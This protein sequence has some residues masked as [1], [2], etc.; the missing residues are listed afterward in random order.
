M[1]IPP[2][3]SPSIRHNPTTRSGPH[4]RLVSVLEDGCNINGLVNAAA[5]HLAALQH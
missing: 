1:N 3:P 5:T 2:G 4:S